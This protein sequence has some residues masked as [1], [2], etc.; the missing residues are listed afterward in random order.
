MRA[1]NRC[2]ISLQVN[3]MSPGVWVVG[4]LGD[5]GHQEHVGQRGMGHVPIPGVK[6]ANLVLVQADLAFGLLAAYGKPTWR[7]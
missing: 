1:A 6:A 2:W 4:T 3:G 5:R 7:V